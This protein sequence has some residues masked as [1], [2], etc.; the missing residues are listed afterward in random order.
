M[1]MFRALY[2]VS[3]I[4]QV[5]GFVMFLCIVALVVIASVAPINMPPRP[6]CEDSNGWTTKVG[7]VCVEPPSI[8]DY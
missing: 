3:R 5:F 7:D 4:N 1:N 6:A 8:M 2:D